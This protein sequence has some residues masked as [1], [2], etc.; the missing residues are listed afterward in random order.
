MYNKLNL[1]C[2]HENQILIFCCFHYIFIIIVI[3]VSFRFLHYF[4]NFIK[5]IL[6]L[7]NNMNINISI[8]IFHE[9]LFFTNKNIYYHFQSHVIFSNIKKSNYI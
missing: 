8:L 6:I 4:Y 1:K 5:L 3:I 2:I 9:P 7:L